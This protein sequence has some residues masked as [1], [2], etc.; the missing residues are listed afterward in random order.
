LDQL[1]SDD[2]IAVRRKRRRALVVVLLA[3]SLATLG[4][5]AMSLAIFTDSTD[6][7]GAWTTGTIDLATDT[8][9]TFNATGIMPG[10]DG[11]QTVNVQNNGTGDLRYALTSSA[12][13]PDDAGLRDELQ[14]TVSEGACGAGGTVLYSGDLNGAFFGDVAQGAQGDDRELAAASDE[15]LCFAWSFPLSADNSFQGSS[16]EATFTF[17]AEQTANN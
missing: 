7:T 1:A 5:G 6:A 3:S 2:R 12:T 15:D 8:S 4:A 9:T 10:D 11:E 14:L 16:T 17:A 13:N